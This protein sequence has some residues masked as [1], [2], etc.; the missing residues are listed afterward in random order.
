MSAR[1]PITETKRPGTENVTPGHSGQLKATVSA[2]EVLR[3]AA[4]IAGDYR[5]AAGASC[6]DMGGEI[7][8]LVDIAIREE[9]TF[10]QAWAKAI[11]QAKGDAESGPVTVQIITGIPEPDQD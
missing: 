5:L 2:H 4:R 6:V 9:K 10:L 1:L 3:E 11:P 8:Y 7:G